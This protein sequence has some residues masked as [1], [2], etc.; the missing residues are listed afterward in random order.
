MVISILIG[1]TLLVN[2]F[3][4]GWC[5]NDFKDKDEKVGATVALSLFGLPMFLAYGIG[6]LISKLCQ[7]IKNL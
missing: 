7:W 3:L 6:I 5:I 4:A 1:I 2:G